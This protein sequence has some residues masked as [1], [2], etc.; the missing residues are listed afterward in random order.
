MGN[1][2]TIQNVCSP[3]E[4]EI[5]FKNSKDVKLTEQNLSSQFFQRPSL[6][7]TREWRNHDKKTHNAEL[8]VIDMKNNTVVGENLF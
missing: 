3:L 1:L 2:N 7:I 5:K 6:L 8:T 4:C